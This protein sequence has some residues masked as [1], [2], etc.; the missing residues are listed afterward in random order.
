MGARKRRIG[1]VVGTEVRGADL[2]RGFDLWEEG[3]TI[4]LE[5][6]IDWVFRSIEALAGAIPLSSS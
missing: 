3:P 5:G 4:W 6:L 2:I 1:G